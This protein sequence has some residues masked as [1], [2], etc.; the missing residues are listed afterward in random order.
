M[1]IDWS[2]PG[3][4]SE[5]KKLAEKKHNVSKCKVQFLWKNKQNYH[6]AY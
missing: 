4:I 6:E 1:V 3:G 5:D 2:Y